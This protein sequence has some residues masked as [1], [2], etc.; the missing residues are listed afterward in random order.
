MQARRRAVTSA[1]SLPLLEAL[2]AETQAIIAVAVAERGDG[3][4]YKTAYLIDRGMTIAAHRQCC[5]SDAERSAGFAPGGPPP[6][7][8]TTAA[9]RLGILCGVEVLL[10]SLAAGLVERGAPAI[11]WCA[12]DIGVP[13]DPLAR[14]RATEAGRIVIAAGVATGIAAANGGGSI[15]DAEGAVFA[16]TVEGQAMAALAEI[17]V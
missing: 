17:R 3:E 7:V 14:A 13:L 15:I 8:V 4:T 11:V 5:L 10:P 16:I 1:E 12:G 6:P 2:S 9:G